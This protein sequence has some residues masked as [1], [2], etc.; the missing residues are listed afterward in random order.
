LAKT[1]AKLRRKIVSLA[2]IAGRRWR[3]PKGR[4]TTGRI[5]RRGFAEDSWIKDAI[6]GNKNATVPGE[7]TMA[8]D[9]GSAPGRGI[10]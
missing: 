7:G 5:G 6:H 1:D 10:L 3:S 2:A 4:T 9:V 8:L